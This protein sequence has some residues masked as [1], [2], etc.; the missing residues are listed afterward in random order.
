MRSVGRLSPDLVPT[1][2][3]RA[4]LPAL[5]LSYLPS[6]IC[7]LVHPFI[8]SLVR[9][10]RSLVNFF[11]TVVPSSFLYFAPSSAQCGLLRSCS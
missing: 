4:F 10:V 8:H 11:P 1:L 5:G 9:S 3:L 7:P 2:I 6:L